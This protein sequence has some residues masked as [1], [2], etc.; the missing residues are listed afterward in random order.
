MSSTEKAPGMIATLVIALPSKHQGGAIQASFGGQ[1]L[2]LET[3]N[4]SAFGFSYL[5]WYS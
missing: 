1:T 5:A 3:E 2:A 4:S